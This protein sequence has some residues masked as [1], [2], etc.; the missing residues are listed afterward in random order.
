MTRAAPPPAGRPRG[1]IRPVGSH[2]RA[3]IVL[4]VV[5]AL[6]AWAPTAQAAVSATPTQIV[7]SGQGGS[8]VIDRSPFHLA[9]RDGAGQTVLS[10]I[11]PPPVPVTP[12]AGA[13][14]TPLGL[15]ASPDGAVYAPLSFQVGAAAAAQY[16]GV[17]YQ[18]NEL[19]AGGAGA[20]FSAQSVSSVTEKDGGV[21]L[22]VATGDPTR[23]LTVL[24][25]PDG[26]NAFRVRSAP[27]NASGVVTIGDAFT[28]APDEA[29]HG[30]GGRHNAIDQRGQDLYSWIAQ[31]NF[32]SD[33][34]GPYFAPLPGNN[35]PNYLFPNGPTAAYY[36]HNA[37]VSSRD[38]GFLLNQ[39]ELTRWHLA[40]DRPDA[41]QVSSGSSSLDYTVAIGPGAQNVRSLS[42][43]NGSQPVPPAWS[44]GPFPY[45]AVSLSGET[46]ATYRNKV[47]SDVSH[48]ENDH[49][50]VTAYD[51][52]GWHALAPD[53][54]RQTNQRLRAA[55]AHPTAYL[56]A[57]VGNDGAFF[58][59]QQI[60]DGAVSKGY[61]ATTATGQPFLYPETTNPAAV[62][63]FTNPDA[64]K[65][66]DRRVTAMLDLGFDGFME[67]FGEQVSEGMHFHDGETGATMH[68]RYPVIYH[69]VTQ[70]ILDRYA[71]AHPQRGPIFA[72]TR[73]G[74]S[75]RPG[76]AP[77]EGANFPGDETADYFHGSGLASLASD[78]LNR[79]VLGSIGFTTDIG[80]Y[81]DSLSGPTDSELFLRW[82]AWSALTPFLRVHNDSN[83]TTKMPW[84]FGPK[85]EA[86]WNALGQLHQR[87]LPL[88]RKLWAAFPSTG[89]P[90]TSPLWLSVPGDRTAAAQDQEWMLGPDVLVAPVVDQGVKSRSVYFPSGC[91]RNPDNGETHRGPGSASASAP[92]Q[93]LP[94]FFRCDTDPFAAAAAAAGP[95]AL[96][97]PSARRCVSRRRFSIRLRV[98]HGDR[99][100]SAAVYVNHHRARVLRGAR[101][102]STVDLRGLPPGR[103]TVLIVARTRHG[104]TL[105]SV[106]AY[107]TCRPRH[108]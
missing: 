14:P 7:L 63:D 83:D 80:G 106:R 76:A 4:G 84:T 52:E 3:G 98:P 21:S 13:D 2:R 57:F 93:S 81:I 50:G 75:G 6:A 43:I 92:V 35:G 12:G 102:R 89:I 103:F 70:A 18:G 40:S 23:A 47:L 8:V 65:W 20:A 54:V 66:W 60:Y 45:R 19:A 97:L 24:I 107:R 73:A 58:D 79:A 78:M 55:G 104:R 31:E 69:Q 88:I 51:Y 64:V 46:P 39:D 87:A 9:F 62:I 61:V 94:Y 49:L 37:F 29:F 82:T 100:R 34:Y 15:R 105:R 72:F 17:L 68:N 99:L 53:F 30:F 44:E 27:Q 11:A 95:A 96:G 74:F 1:S 36:I 22:E 41:W 77:F 38:Y 26:A 71:K 85:V 10:E 59:D 86:Q 67:D 16:F 28:S 33:K 25:T 90:P 101:L 56:R 5:C 32:G 91:W 48:I 108:R 42:A